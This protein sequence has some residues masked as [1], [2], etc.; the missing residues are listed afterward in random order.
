MLLTSVE[1]APIKIFLRA[2]FSH[3]ENPHPIGAFTESV[4][5]N[6]EFFFNRNHRKKCRFLLASP[7]VGLAVYIKYLNIIYHLITYETT[8]SYHT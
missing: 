7:A 2:S 4:N 8:V 6:C 1:S 5:A 3:N